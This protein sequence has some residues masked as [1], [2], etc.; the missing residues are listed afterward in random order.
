MSL[1]SEQNKFN[2]TNVTQ[3]NSIYLI[4]FNCLIVCARLQFGMHRL[5]RQCSLNAVKLMPS[6]TSKRQSY[7]FEAYNPQR[8]W[9][10]FC[11]IYSIPLNTCVPL[12]AEVTLASKMWLWIFNV[13]SSRIKRSIGFDWFFLCCVFDFVRLP[14][15]I[16]LNPWIEVD[17]N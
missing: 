5:C 17:W 9:S 4:V 15:L 2:G 8:I 12:W 13:T 7:T 10:H 14:N 1:I 6:L 11:G 3:P 16:K